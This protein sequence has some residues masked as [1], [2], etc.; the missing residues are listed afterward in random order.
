LG[1]HRSGQGYKKISAALKVPKIS[2]TVRNGIRKWKATG[3]VAVKP[4]RSGRQRKIQERHMSRIVRM[5]TDNPQITS[6]D[7]Q[8]HLAADGVSVHR[9]TI[10]R[11]LH[12][13]HLYGRVMRKKTF[14]HSCHKPSRL[15]YANAHLDKPDSFWNKVLW[16]DETK[17][18]L[19]VL[20]SY[21]C[22]GAHIYAPV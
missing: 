19:F 8:E 21:L 22:W 9:S 12:K 2:V 11:N 3:T 14:L 5:V 7:L 1:K 15:L 10:Q 4:S 18:E 13:E 16:T 17:I 20:M 6:T